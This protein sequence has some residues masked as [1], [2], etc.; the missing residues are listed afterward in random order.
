MKQ[1]I[2]RAMQEAIERA[3]STM[4]LG[5]GGPFGAAVIR[6]G[7]V[8]AVASNT[9]LKDHDPS[10]HAEMNAIRRASQILES[11]D[12]TG[13]V[14]YTTGHPC[15]MCL[16]AIIWANIKTVY[17]GCEAYEADE[18]GFRDDFIYKFIEGECKE[19]KILS[20]TQYGH[21]ECKAL[22]SEYEKIQHELY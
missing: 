9:V 1:T 22:Y 15:P 12:L 3:R 11:H 2:D 13:C 21:T 10:A 4:R 19:E 16:A 6:E 14:L 17:F 18:I 20:L 5:Y 7:H 8:I